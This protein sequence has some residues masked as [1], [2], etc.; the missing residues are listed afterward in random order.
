MR[1][2]TSARQTTNGAI[3]ELVG[4]HGRSAEV[5]AELSIEL[6]EKRNR[7]RRELTVTFEEKSRIEN[8]PCR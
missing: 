4:N 6:S 5:E 8:G 7:S 3:N 2:S 1:A